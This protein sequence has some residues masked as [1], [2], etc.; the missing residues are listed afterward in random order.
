MLT[1]FLTIRNILGGHSKIEQAATWLFCE[2]EKLETTTNQRCAL[3]VTQKTKCECGWD[4]NLVPERRILDS[5]KVVLWEE[6]FC[7]L[8]ER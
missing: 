6:F 8:F 1:P 4:D 5:E 2:S 7:P 3:L